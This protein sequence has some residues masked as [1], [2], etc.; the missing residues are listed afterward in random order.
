MSPSSVLLYKKLFKQIIKLAPVAAVCRSG[1]AVPSLGPFF[2]EASLFLRW[3]FQRKSRRS[4]DVNHSLSARHTTLSYHVKY[5]HFRLHNQRLS[6][7]RNVVVRIPRVERE[8]MIGQARVFNFP[9]ETG[10]NLSIHKWREAWLIMDA[11]NDWG[12]NQ[13]PPNLKSAFLTTRQQLWS[14]ISCCRNRFAWRC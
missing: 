10:I 6:K 5:L 7:L 3:L 14:E 9:V 2:L 1:F 12:K 4:L 13:V 8:S 11:W